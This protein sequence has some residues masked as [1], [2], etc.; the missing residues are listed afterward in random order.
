MSFVIQANVLVKYKPDD[1]GNVII[2][3]GV[4]TIDHN[5]FKECADLKSVEIPSSVTEIG[6]YA[7]SWCDKLENVEISAS[8]TKI[9]N[10]AF[11]Y[12]SNL[13]RVVISDG[14]VE[15]GDY[16]FKNCGS[17]E[18]VEV[19]AIIMAIGKEAFRD[20]KSLES[21]D[22]PI[23]SASDNVIKIGTFYNCESLKNIKIPSGV[24]EIGP[25]AFS[26]CK[27]LKNIKIPSSVTAIGY[28]AFYNCK[29]LESIEIPVGVT[30]IRRAVFYNCKSLKNIKI[31]SG[32]TA[33]DYEAFYNCKSLENIEIPAS[34]NEIGFDAFEGTKWLEKKGNENQ[35]FII[36]NRVIDGRRCYGDVVIPEGV[37]DIRDDA[38]ESID[39]SAPKIKS[40]TI[41]ATLNNIPEYTFIDCEN[42]ENIT[43]AEDNK[44]YSSQD[45]ILFNKDKTIIIK[46]P[47]NK[48]DAE[49]VLEENMTALTRAIPPNAKVILKNNNIQVSFK[50]LGYWDFNK[51]ESNLKELCENKTYEN[52]VKLKKTAYKYPIAIYMA[53]T[54]TLEDSE[55]KAYLKKNAKKIIKWLI[56]EK[57]IE[58]LTLILPL[59]FVTNKNIDEFIVYAKNSRRADSR[60]LLEEYKAQNF[61]EEQPKVTKTKSTSKTKAKKETTNEEDFVIERKILKG[62]LKKKY[63]TLELPEG[64]TSI[65]KT[66]FADVTVKKL[67][68]PQ[69]IQKISAQNFKDC[70]NISEVVIQDGTTEIGEKAFY[71]CKK[72]TTVTIAD[73]VSSI[74]T[75]AFKGCVKLKTINI[76]KSVTS[77][78]IFTTFE[79]CKK[80]EEI[81]ISPENKNIK[82]IDNVIYL[83]D[84]T[85]ILYYPKT[86][87][88]ITISENVEYICESDAKLKELTIKFDSDNVTNKED[89]LWNDLSFVYV[90]KYNFRFVEVVNFQFPSKTYTF[91]LK[92]AIADISYS[93][94]LMDGN[95]VKVK[96]EVNIFVNYFC[97]IML[98]GEFNKYFGDVD[99]AFYHP[100][101]KLRFHMAEVIAE[102]HGKNCE[103]VVD[104]VI[105]CISE[106]V[107]EGDLDNGDVQYELKK[108][109]TDGLTAYP[110]Y[111]NKFMSINWSLKYFDELIFD[112]CCENKDYFEYIIKNN[113]STDFIK[114]L[115]NQERV[116]VIYDIVQSKNDLITADNIDELVVYANEQK[117]TE[118]QM[119]LM[120]YKNE[121][122]GYKSIDEEFKI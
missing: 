79:E 57:D 61:A 107:Y 46:V 19:S 58:S 51:E 26:N 41:P 56:D 81:N 11:D 23:S 34:V 110:Q 103:D 97:R 112:Y 65:S 22:I 12:C 73:T 33:I 120:N 100:L 17:L 53:L 24:T 106:N 85:Q 10:Y 3:D 50:M 94:F 15:I 63:T 84:E 119:R 6:S 49:C 5:A 4:T 74:G 36:N 91:D 87:S 99:N 121:N 122:I 68:L 21:M 96:D 93:P 115:I 118:I 66:A 78:S 104:E 76:G 31:P 64:I 32:V 88:S 83:K 28:E 44:N 80:I 67:V 101:L 77:N 95:Y 52:F 20:C 40:I 72:L 117:Q 98:L 35:L 70:I 86:K 27:N 102:I 37:T 45:G 82:S 109:I 92:D 30:A 25:H 75:R 71:G 108:E 2:P 105:K 13:K 89:N 90:R 60:K 18:N 42:L 9:G 69:S 14:T 111:I 8:V 39:G 43:V 48:K 113:V 62:V 116:N 38:F 114:Y 7:F 1:D 59:G 55:F 16:A 54:Q 29:S 47:E